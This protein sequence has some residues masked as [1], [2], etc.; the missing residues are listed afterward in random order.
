MYQWDSFVLSNNKSLVNFKQL[1]EQ[2]YRMYRSIMQYIDCAILDPQT[3]THKPKV[4]V[5]SF[6]YLIVGL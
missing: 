6:L 1:D 3:F 5:C 2:S 4:L